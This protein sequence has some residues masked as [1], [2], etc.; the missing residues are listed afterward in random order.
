MV[1]YNVDLYISSRIL[2]VPD[3]V[4]K[5]KYKK[6]IETASMIRK[7]EMLVMW[8]RHLFLNI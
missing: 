2:S 5:R 4:L 1:E 8:N 7:S 3:K 6:A